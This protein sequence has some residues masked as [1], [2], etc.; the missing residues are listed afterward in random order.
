MLDP[1]KAAR[2]LI[3]GVGLVVA[4]IGGAGGVQHRWRPFDGAVKI[5]LF[6]PDARERPAAASGAGVRVIPEALAAA[7]CTITLHLC[8]KPMLS[9]VYEPNR[10]YLDR[11]PDAAR[12]DVVGR[13]EVRAT[14]L[15]AWC[16]SERLAPDFLK[17]DT[18]G[19]ELEILKGATETL[20]SLLGLEVEIAFQ[21]LRTGQPLCED[22]VAHLRGK[23]FE[24]HDLL[25]IYRWNRDGHALFGQIALADALFITSPETVLLRL[26]SESAEQR[27]ALA[28]KYLF[29]CAV[30]R[31]ADVFGAALPMLRPYL[32]PE[33][34]AA[35]DCVLR[36][37][38]RRQRLLEGLLHGCWRLTARFGQMPMP[39]WN[40]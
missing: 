35:A 20:D 31:L 14:T 25:R 9:S 22:I 36:R 28:S 11:F 32:G 6:E 30:Y 16:G 12:F 13:S 7:G 18:E 2:A 1:D 24:L 17:I 27:A 33:R 23:G 38:R 29:L 10:T 34:I 39:F 15:D 5:L 21:P 26:A 4:D 3:D 40:R 37:L 8:R 19:S